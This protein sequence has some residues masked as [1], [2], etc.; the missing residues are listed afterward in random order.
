[1]DPSP[2][3]R[4]GLSRVL[5]A[6]L[7]LVVADEAAANPITPDTTTSSVCSNSPPGARSEARS[8]A[9]KVLGIPGYVDKQL[10]TPQTRYT[11]FEP[12]PANRPATC[13]DDRTLPLT[14]TSYCA[15][16]NYTL[17]QLQREFFANAVIRRRTSCASASRLRCRRSS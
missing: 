6:A 15:R 11:T 3:G 9:V 2:T 13:L 10:A 4:S 17:F 12:W 16:D 14:P 8:T 1:M 7:S 5:A